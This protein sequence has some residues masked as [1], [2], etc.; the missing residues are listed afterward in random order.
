LF[1]LK[2]CTGTTQY[3]YLPTY[4]TII[5]VRRFPFAGTGW[6]LMVF[7]YITL[8]THVQAEEGGGGGRGIR[9]KINRHQLENAE[10]NKKWMAFHDYH[11]VLRVLHWKGAINY[12]QQ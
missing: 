2:V 6:S 4:R 3:T 10:I 11:F 7:M 5:S 1:E 8:N 12:V 9:Q